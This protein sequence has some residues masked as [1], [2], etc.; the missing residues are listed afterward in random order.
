[1]ARETK[2]YLTHDPNFE[3]TVDN[4]DSFM[5]G[6]LGGLD[7]QIDHEVDLS[8]KNPALEH[9]DTTS[10]K[11]ITEKMLADDAAQSSQPQVY[12][13]TLEEVNTG[14][15]P[16]QTGSLPIIQQAKPTFGT[17]TDPR[18]LETPPTSSPQ[19]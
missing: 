10:L 15:I 14:S 8:Q 16:L 17:P 5:Y 7:A 18:A 9:P 19:E 2:K 12:D 6:H 11:I 3:A 4:I 13:V 1:M